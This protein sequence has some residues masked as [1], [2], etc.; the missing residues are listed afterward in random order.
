MSFPAELAIVLGGFAASKIAFFVMC[1]GQILTVVYAFLFL[2][3]VI[4]GEQKE[5]F[6]KVWADLNLREI[7][8][9]LGC[10][11]PVI[12]FGLFP[13]LIFDVIGRFTSAV[14]LEITLRGLKL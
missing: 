5:L 7:L 9:I 3:R 1:I 12:L 10:I 11:V 4:F 6:Q 14:V 13:N 2:N 8:L